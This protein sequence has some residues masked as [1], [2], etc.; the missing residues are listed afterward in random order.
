MV[1]REDLSLRE[2][3]DLARECTRGAKSEAEVR[4]RLNNAGFSGDAAAV[5][6]YTNEHGSMFMATIH[7]PEGELIDI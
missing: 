6:F 1:N 2:A 4:Q 7:G 3:E 5:S